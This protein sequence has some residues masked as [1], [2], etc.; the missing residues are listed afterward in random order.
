MINIMLTTFLEITALFA[1]LVIPMTGPK[2]KKNKQ[3]NIERD[4]SNA[5]YAIDEDGNLVELHGRELS[6]HEH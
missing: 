5:H 3:L 2:K 1:I 4:V 6:R